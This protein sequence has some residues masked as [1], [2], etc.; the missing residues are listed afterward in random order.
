M[1]CLEEHGKTVRSALLSKM[2][3]TLKITYAICRY[4]VEE[5]YIGQA[6]DKN[7]VTSR[8][9]FYQTNASSHTPDQAACEVD[10]G[11]VRAP[12]EIDAARRAEML[13]IHQQ[14]NDGFIGRTQDVAPRN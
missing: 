10:G 14:V 12:A 5:Y 3:P 13:Q 1:C 9:S 7:A 6:V 8:S 11:D 2:S 4:L